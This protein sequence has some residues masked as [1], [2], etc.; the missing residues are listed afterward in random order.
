MLSLTEDRQV[1]FGFFGIPCQDSLE[2][3]EQKRLARQRGQ[4]SQRSQCKRSRQLDVLVRRSEPQAS[5]S[6]QAAVIEVP[7]AAEAGCLRQKQ[8]RVPCHFLF[9]TDVF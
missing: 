2:R 4:R 7:R 1:L 3:P 9:E 5:A 8:T 6:P